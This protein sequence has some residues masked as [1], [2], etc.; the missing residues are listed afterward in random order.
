M[1]IWMVIMVLSQYGILEMT[2][3]IEEDDFRNVE[4][5][6]FVARETKWTAQGDSE[7]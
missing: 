4:E 1:L 6:S 5:K 2:K 7:S 3:M